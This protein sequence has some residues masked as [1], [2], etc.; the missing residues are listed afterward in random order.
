M[1]ATGTFFTFNN[2]EYLSHAIVVAGYDDTLELLGL[3]DS[4]LVH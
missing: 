4:K 3:G 2:S 1:I